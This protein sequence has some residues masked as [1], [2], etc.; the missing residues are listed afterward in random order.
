MDHIAGSGEYNRAAIILAGGEGTRL[1][2]LTRKMAGFPVPKQFCAL[3]GETPLLEETRRR[4]ARSVPPDHTVFA[5]NHDHEGFFAPLLAG[6]PA[7]NLVV[8]PGNRGTAPAILYSLLRLAEVAPGAA[9]LLTPSDHHVGDEAALTKYVEL[10][11]ATVEERPELTVLLGVTPDEPETSYGWIERG[12]ALSVRH[13]A[14]FQVRRFWE[15]PAREIA[16]ELMANGCLW[17]SF[18]I[19]GRMST[20]LSLFIAGLRELYVMFSKVRPCLGT[21]F[22]EETVRR[23]YAHLRP[24]D[25]SRHVLESATANLSVLPV[26]NVGWSDLGEP[27]RVAKVLASLGIRQKWAAA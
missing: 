20:L 13:G 16:R 26:S 12:P 10:A 19:V 15:K 4:V 14:V 1:S 23:L 21:V 5:L 24:S 11:F 2:D 17:N 22:E 18:M 3:L 7:R 8:Q 27:N 6:V 9:A 25:F